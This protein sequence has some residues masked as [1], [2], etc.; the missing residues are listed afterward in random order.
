MKKLLLCLLLFGCCALEAQQ[1]T[2]ASYNIRNKNA[3]DS[4]NGNVWQVRSEVICQQINTEEPIV[5]GTQEVLY[6]QLLDMLTLLDNYDYIGVGRED[7][8]QGGEYSAIFYKK[9]K[10]KKL[11]EGW[12]WLSTTPDKPSKGW[13]AACTRICTWGK[14]QHRQT[15]KVFFFF[16]LHMDHVGIVARR[17]SA[18]LVIEKIKQLAANNPTILTGDFNIDQTNEIYSIFTSSNILK[19][20]Y[21][22][23][24]HVLAPNGTFNSFDPKLKTS[25]RVDHIFVSPN[26]RVDSYAIHTDIYWTSNKKD[27]KIKGNDAPNEINFDTCTPRTPSDHYPVFVRLEL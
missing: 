21:S 4:L 15:N 9:D 16:N 27:N 18:K 23:A 2:V 5:F 19:D 11:D 20:S 25:S 8:K 14:F 6:T 17:E 24:K 13:D 22:T 1:V 26:L 12:F 10:L 3:S 7:G